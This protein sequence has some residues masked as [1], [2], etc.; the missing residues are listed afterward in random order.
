MHPSQLSSFKI[1]MKGAGV[2]I[3]ATIWWLPP[4]RAF[5]CSLWTAV[6]QQSQM[7]KSTK[8]LSKTADPHNV[9]QGSCQRGKEK[10]CVLHY[11]DLHTFSTGVQQCPHECRWNCFFWR[12]RTDMN[13]QPTPLNGSG[14]D[15]WALLPLKMCL[16]KCDL[17][18]E[19]IRSLENHTTNPAII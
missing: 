3:W 5:F 4:H 14:P 16:Q 10:E 12:I 2:M 8:T 6:K 9:K 11:T 13:P 17:H 18:T 15:Q 1:L 19:N 7:Y